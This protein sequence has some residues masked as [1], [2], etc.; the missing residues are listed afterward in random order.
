MKKVLEF[1]KEKKFY[2]MIIPS[3]LFLIIL[4]Y[5]PLIK[6]ISMSFFKL[7]QN[8]S[9]IESFTL[10]NYYKFF[11]NNI[12]IKILIR[13]LRV[14]LL[15]SIFCLVLAYPLALLISNFK[16]KLS[17]FSLLI[18][19]I[20]FLVNELIRNYSW[21]VIFQ[22][23]GLLNKLLLK[24]GLIKN[25]IRLI[26]TELGVII[27]IVHIL[28]PFMI[29]FVYNSLIKINENI[30]LSALSLQAT[31][32]QVFY[33]IVF[34]LSVPSVVAGL[35][36]VFLISLGLYMTPILIGGPKNMTISFLISQQILTMLNWSFAATLSTI[37][38]VIVILI[39]YYFKKFFNLKNVV[40][41]DE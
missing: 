34:P 3:I 16:T 15:S 32:F 17:Y 12:Y 25:P 6:I 35:T 2:L 27:S 19:F 26:G 31:P 24:V 37:M 30:K 5:V 23:N 28:V 11:S 39:I 13:S 41:I 29:I 8:N 18:I 10:E 21:M 14:S 33:K 40:R 20:S 4:F 7:S 38:L 22:T 36:V 1:L 9:L